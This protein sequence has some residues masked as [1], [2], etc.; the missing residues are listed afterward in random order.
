MAWIL[1][2][3]KTGV[4]GETQGTDLMEI[5]KPD[6]LGD[7][8]N[9]GLTLSEAK[10]VLANVQRE[11]ATA[12]ARDHVVRRPDCSRRDG[13]CR[14]KDFREHA[15]AM[16]FGEVTIKLPRF[17]CARRGGTETGIGWPTH[18]RSTPELD[19]IRAQLSSL[20]TYRMAADLLKQMF[21]VDAGTYPET[22]RRHTL[23]TGE[24]LA[25]CA[26]TRPETAAPVIAITLDSAFVR[27]CEDG[28]RHLEVR[29]GN[30]ETKSGGRQVFG[31]VAKADTDIEVLIRRNLDAIGR[32]EG[33][34]LT[35]FTDSCPATGCGFL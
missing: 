11:I 24:A 31:A 19:R 12:Q 16:L 33:T 26:A 8:V 32:I 1:R 10:L 15:V 4:D 2:L 14:M 7:I 29:V 22:L 34:E 28:E 9:L 30:V 5:R 20:M 18:C 21:P 23:R 25:D 17:R 6:G 3:V 35:A 13:V 27:S